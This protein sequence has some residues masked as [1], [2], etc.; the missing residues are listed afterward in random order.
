[1]K[2]AYY[3]CNS[4]SNVNLA[5]AVVEEQFAVE[6][7]LFSPTPDVWEGIEA[8][9]RLRWRERGILS[10]AKSK[11]ATEKIDVLF[12]LQ[13]ALA[14]KNASGVIPDDVAKTQIDEL[15]TKIGEL[16]QGIFQAKPGIS[17]EEALAFSKR[18]L[19]DL[20]LRWAG[21][22]LNAKRAIQTF[23]Y[24]NGITYVAE[25]GYRTGEYVLLEEIKRVLREGV[26]C[27]VSQDLDCT[28]QTTLTQDSLLGNTDPLGESDL[29]QVFDW[30]VSLE[31][32]LGE[33]QKE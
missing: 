7:Q 2:Y 32:Y 12:K 28:N 9:V 4:C 8:A 15:S 31:S 24:P 25:S 30:I 20:G 18:F 27:V 22:P 1:M 26:S 14:L 5:K 29:Q 23:L 11:S 19:T 13:K 16:S 6:L 21:M 17:L 10:E 33:R 3:R